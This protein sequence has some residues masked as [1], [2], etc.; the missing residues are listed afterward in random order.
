MTA[1]DKQIADLREIAGYCFFDHEQALL[2]AVLE[3]L[4][5]LRELRDAVDAEDW[6]PGT[7]I[8]EALAKCQ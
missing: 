4:A 5:T 2:E 8:A 6:T 7:A 3:E 1:T